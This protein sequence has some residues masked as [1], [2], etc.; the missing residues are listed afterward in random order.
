MIDDWH[1]VYP[2]AGPRHPD[3]VAEHWIGLIDDAA[4]RGGL[5]TQIIHPFVT[6]VDDARMAALRRVLAHA[7]E[8]PCVDIQSAD[9]VADAYSS[10]K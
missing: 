2:P 8:H 9:E 6:G 5:V 7:V 10:E 3:T 4:N 1:Y